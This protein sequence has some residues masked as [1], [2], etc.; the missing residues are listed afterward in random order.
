ML[1]GD[2]TE[3]IVCRWDITRHCNLKCAHCYNYRDQN[4][5]ECRQELNFDQ[6]CHVAH[7]LRRGG[8]TSIV[9]LG[10]EPLIRK[11][12]MSII[13]MF[14]QLGF[15]ISLNTNGTIMNKELAK[16][17]IR[18]CSQ[19]NFSIDGEETAHDS[20]RGQ[21]TYRQALNGLKEVLATRIIEQS[22]VQIGINSVISRLNYH[23]MPEFV[24]QMGN[25]GVDYIIVSQIAKEGRAINN[26]KTL[27]LSPNQLLEAGRAMFKHFDATMKPYVYP[28]F[29]SNCAIA[30]LVSCFGHRIPYRQYFCQGG[31]SECFVRENGEM[32]P[33][34]YLG[35]IDRD[36]IMRW[37]WDFSNNNLLLSSFSEIWHSDA[38]KNTRTLRARHVHRTYY[39]S[40]AKCKFSYS[41]CLP[42]TK[43]FVH[44]NQDPFPLCSYVQQLLVS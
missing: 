23:K 2:Q 33:C 4:S 34:Q 10:G 7:N 44:G 40:C 12:C 36:A 30:Y 37:P 27:E 42:C 16:K 14:C 1:F 26:W 31:I 38:F 19:I 6:I 32:F 25:L 5:S 28:S 17:L 43:H 13:A 20:L 35:H 18:S 22:Q 9:L 15:R 8:V 29:L 41:Y 21:G 3:P 24:R 39:L 11:D